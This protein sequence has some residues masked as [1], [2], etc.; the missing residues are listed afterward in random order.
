MKPGGGMM[1]PPAAGGG[2]G[3]GAFGQSKEA[4][5]VYSGGGPVASIID[6][7]KKR[8]LDAN[9][10]VRRMPVSVTVVVDQAYLQDVLLA[11]AN[12]ALRFQITQVT[13][14]RFHGT[15]DLGGG[16]SGSSGESGSVIYGGQTQFGA[17][18]GTSGGL[19][20]G[21][22][23]PGSLSG[24]PPRTSGPGPGGP[25]GP[26][27]GPGSMGSFGMTGQPSTV[28]ESQLTSG[29]VELTVYGVVSLYSS[30][31][32]A[33]ADAAP[34]KEPSPKD[35]EQPKDKDKLPAD[36]KDKAPADKKDKAPADKTD[37]KGKAPAD[38]DSK[39]KTPAG[40]EPETKTPDSK[41]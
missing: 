16:S 32:A 31:E 17:G 40:K 36:K 12:S 8:Y 4:T 5:A 7:N 6:G 13:L 18:F 11:F 14:N 39:D 29:L 23:G 3:G 34:K 30:P 9:D 19:K 26:G 2:G 22:P 1:M 35:K 24:G 20:P 27:M 15:L 25:G 33:A 28:A 37:T 38:K 10:Q 21:G 41:K